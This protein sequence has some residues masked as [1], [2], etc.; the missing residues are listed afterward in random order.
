MR[1][2]DIFNGEYFTT[3]I[4]TYRKVSETHAKC[5]KSSIQKIN[6]DYRFNNSCVVELLG[7]KAFFV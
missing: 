4:G 3:A 1:F 2:S 6:V 5:V 7:E